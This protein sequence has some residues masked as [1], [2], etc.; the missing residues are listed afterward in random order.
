MRKFKDLKGREW[1]VE[2]TV[3]GVVEVRQAVE[4]DLGKLFADDMQKLGELLDDLPKLVDVLWLL[5]AEQAKAA[6]V[7]P[8]D[9][10]RALA[11]DVLQGA[12]DAL[13]DS[14]IDF[15]PNARQRELRRQILQKSRAAFGILADRGEAELQNLDPQ[16]LC[17][18]A[19]N[20]RGLPASTPAT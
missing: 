20:S 19:M 16:T 11:G 18:F 5:C 15:F 1:S 12:A 9:F 4:I 2:V 10:G 3:Q 7:A 13:I 8:E 6:G 17:D 14:T